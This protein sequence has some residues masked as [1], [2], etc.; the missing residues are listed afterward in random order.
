VTEKEVTQRAKCECGHTAQRHTVCGL[1]GREA[2]GICRMK[3]CSCQRFVRRKRMSPPEP[4]DPGTP[5]GLRP[6]E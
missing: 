6:L 5:T 1:L 2:P 4:V 3:G